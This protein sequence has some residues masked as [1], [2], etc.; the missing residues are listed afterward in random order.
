MIQCPLF[1]CLYYFLLGATDAP[2]ATATP[3]TET[4]VTPV[5]TTTAT[6]NVTTDDVEMS[7]DQTAKPATPKAVPLM[8]YIH[9]V[10]CTT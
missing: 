1:V 8:D 5:I 10:V 2:A 9:N 7:S 6:E 3:A 4:P